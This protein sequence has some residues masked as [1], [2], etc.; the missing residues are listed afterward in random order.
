MPFSMHKYHFPLY[1]N[2]PQQVLSY[3]DKVFVAV[4]TPLT[5]EL[6]PSI[7][8]IHTYYYAVAVESMLQ[9]PE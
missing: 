1:S 8:R 4:Y 5:F 7:Q 2:T 3:F 6:I 9:Q